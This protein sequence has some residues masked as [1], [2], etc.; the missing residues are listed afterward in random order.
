MTAGLN[1]KDQHSSQGK[2]MR[3][4]SP[5]SWGMLA[6]AVVCLFV[7]SCLAGLLLP[8]VSRRGGANRT[9]CMS[10]IR[11]IAVALHNYAAAN[12]GFLPPAYIADANGRPMHSWRALMLP[13][14]DRPDL[15]QAYRFDEPWDGPNNSKLH[16]IVEDVF[17]CPEDKGGTNSTQTSY[18]AIVGP[19]TAWPGTTS[20]NLEA[21]AAGDGLA[22]TILIAE[23]ANSGIHWLEP[24]DLHLSQMAPTINS[25][26]GQG[27]SGRHSGYAV[28]AFADG[29]V[30]PISDN[31]S[32]A[33]LRA[34]LTING[35][36]PVADG[37]F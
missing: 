17:R 35:N 31:L 29:R 37:D 9:Q 8:E 11:N 6:K 20:V 10:N 2:I 28:V 12:S 1:H 4:E 26:T 27:I 30:K 13:Y 24:R 14:I 34:L 15:A 33:K 23:V 22:Q 18:V 5:F 3:D 19:E 7:A 32:A 21:I 36:D 16:S 25:H